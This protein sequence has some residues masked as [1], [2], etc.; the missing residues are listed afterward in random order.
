MTHFRLKVEPVRGLGDDSTANSV[1]FRCS[2]GWNGRQILEASN[3]GPWGDWRSWLGNYNGS[4][5]C[6]VRAKVE[7]PVGL[8]DDTA[9]NNLQFSWCSL[10]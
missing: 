9:L 2:N 7:A 4:A 10:P 5:I 8:G 3:G 1:A 6:G